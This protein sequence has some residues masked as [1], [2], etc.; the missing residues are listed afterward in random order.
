M[1]K[2]DKSQEERSLILMCL[3][4][5]LLGQS[6]QEVLRYRDNAELCILRVHKFGIWLATKHQQ[7]TGKLWTYG[8]NCCTAMFA[9]CDA[10]PLYR[11][12]GGIID[13]DDTNVFYT[14][15]VVLT[16]RK[17][18]IQKVF[19]LIAKL[20]NFT[21]SMY[22]SSAFFIHVEGYMRTVPDLMKVIFAIGRDDLDGDEHVHEYW[23]S[24]K[25]NY[26]CYNNAELRL[27]VVEMCA[28][29]YADHILNS[30]ALGIL[31]EHVAN[32]TNDE[33]LFKEHWNGSKEVRA[34]KINPVKRREIHRRQ[35][36]AGTDVI[37]D[38]Y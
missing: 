22:G 28:E 14:S 33:E 16:D 9:L 2:Y 10:Y 12:I 17:E 23:I 38:T 7:K 35:N 25:D 30:A 29:R 24:F 37:Y 11:A 26:A 20:E 34:R 36:L 19:N 21:L 18:Y 15:D 8:G 32:L 6:M 31:A 3:L 5:L 4:M 27:K 1:S 13:S